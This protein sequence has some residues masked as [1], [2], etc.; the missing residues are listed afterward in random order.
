MLAYIKKPRSP[1]LPKSH[2]GNL[3][4]ASLC[5]LLSG[6]LSHHSS[7]STEQIQPKDGSRCREQTREYTRYEAHGRKS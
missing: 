5:R 2:L 7:A 6:F 3:V 1:S 4:K